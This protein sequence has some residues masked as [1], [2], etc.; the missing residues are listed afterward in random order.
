MNAMMNE[1]LFRSDRSLHD[2]GFSPNAIPSRKCV[3]KRSY[4]APQT[5][6][7]YVYHRSS[8]LHVKY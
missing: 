8:L 5:T 4:Y 3:A 2:A 6:E 1:H 7:N